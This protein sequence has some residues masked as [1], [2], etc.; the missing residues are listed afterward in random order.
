MAKNPR[1]STEYEQI[2]RNKKCNASW[3]KE[4]PQKRH[5]NNFGFFPMDSNLKNEKLSL[6][7]KND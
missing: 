1:I 5:K 7:Q 2:Q 3:L 6:P 4:K